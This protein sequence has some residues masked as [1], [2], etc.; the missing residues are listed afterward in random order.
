MYHNPEFNL[1]N[2]HRFKNETL[3]SGEQTKGLL[4]IYEQEVLNNNFS[5]LAEI[6]QVLF[7]GSQFYAD[8]GTEE[9]NNLIYKISPDKKIKFNRFPKSVEKY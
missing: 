3:L 5:H 7:E 8:I 4:E 2:L 1:E 9:I 6:Y